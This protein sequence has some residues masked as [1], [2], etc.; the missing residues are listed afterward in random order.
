[1]QQQLIQ[2]RSWAIRNGGIMLFRAL[3]DRLIGTNATGHRDDVSVDWS[4]GSSRI[5]YKK[6]S[7]L[8][9]LLPQLL[10]EP[11]AA[12][13]Q[14]DY[15]PN[16]ALEHSVQM[17][18]P[19]LDLLRRAGPP[20]EQYDEL[21]R[22]V[23]NQLSNRV[24]HIRDLAARTYT[25]F[26]SLNATNI[27]D[28]AIGEFERLFPTGCRS[29][30]GIHGR[31]LAIRYIIEKLENAD[32]DASKCTAS[33]HDMILIVIHLP[34]PQASGLWTSLCPRLICYGTCVLSPRL[35]FSIQ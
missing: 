26:V 35:P 33:T 28:D 2:L 19:A 17:V 12:E 1:M 5:S 8:S 6:Y 10:R 31:L 21:K 16:L 14:S 25:T 27:S 11:P 30:N 32:A 15:T 24:W 20:Q 4:H 3:I 18:F 22:L 29:Q 34:L 7:S 23:F 13:T 9:S